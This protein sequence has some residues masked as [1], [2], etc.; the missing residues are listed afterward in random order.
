MMLVVDANII[1]QALVKRGFIFR[2]IKQLVKDGVNLYSP[3]FVLEEIKNREEKLLKYSGLTSAELEFV[4][5]LLFKKIEVIPKSKY[6]K[7]IPEASEIF[8]LHTKDVA[9]FALALFNNSELWSDE[10]RHK[11][12]GMVRV[13]STSDLLKKLG[14]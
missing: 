3:E 10:K 14:R 4:I 6:A 9:Y 11:K 12:Q 7:F 5:R 8:P 1:F 13:F 2:L